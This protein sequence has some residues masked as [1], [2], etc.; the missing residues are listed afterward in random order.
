MPVDRWRDV[1]YGRIVINYRPEKYD[2]YRVRLT[3]RGDI[4]SFPWDCGTPKVDM[5]T[6]NLLLTSIVSI[7][8]AKLMTINIKDFYLNTTM[9]RYKYMRLK[10]S[11]LPD[12]VIRQYNLREK[13]ATKAELCALFI[14][15]LEVIT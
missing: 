11:D 3:V 2:P 6:V 1:T 13:V 10:L 8:N 5:L 4:I 12:N 14:N 15:F 7:P 9:P